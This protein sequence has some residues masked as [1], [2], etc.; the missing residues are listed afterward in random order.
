MRYAIYGVN[1][2]AKDFL[3]VFD[4][5]DVVCFFDESGGMEFMGRQV[6]SIKD[7]HERRTEWDKLILCDFDKEAKR[8]RLEQMGLRQGIEFIYEED[9]FYELDDL[10]LNPERKKIAV[11]GTGRRAEAFRIWNKRYTVEL[12]IDSYKKQ[13]AF[14]GIPIKEPS[15]IQDWKE[16]FIIIAAADDREIKNRLKAEGLE[17]YKD[18]C[19]SQEIMWI[20]SELLRETIFE[21]ERYDFQCDTMLNHAELG[22]EGAIHSCCTTFVDIAIG[23]IHK[24]G[25]N[26]IWQGAI[27]KILC[28]SLQNRTY[29][30]CKKDMCPLFIGRKPSENQEIDVRYSPMEKKP[31][32]VLLG[33]DETCNLKCVTCRHELRIAKGE[34]L[35]KVQ[36]YAKAA[37][38]ELLPDCE[39][40]ILAGNG[41]VFASQAYKQVYTNERMEHIKQL[42]LL[43]NGTLFTENNWNSIKRG[44]NMKVMLTVSIDAASKETYE[45]IRRGGSFEQLQKNMLFASQLRKKGDLSY[46]RMNFVVQKAN[47]REMTDFVKWGLELGADEV[48]FTKILNWGTYTEAEFREVSMMEEDGI[49]PKAELQEVLDKPIMNQPIVDM[50]TIR[51]SHRQVKDTDNVQNYYM[52]ELERKV[53]D[54]FDSSRGEE[55]QE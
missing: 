16:Q 22:N 30:F 32:T 5:L 27:H 12:Y 31:S 51:S 11:W 49:T 26:E 6:Y 42:R 33:Y 24:R 20:P 53:P 35:Q 28:L 25:F 7:F 41:E 37:V 55:R 48:F 9:M 19:N 54:L 44:E 38:D 46:F 43:T 34:A 17:E 39:F 45:K 23:N 29:S 14:Y 2:V 4:K 21:K 1:R 10:A 52:W 15:E 13:E 18:F 50:G 47:Y 36:G 3:Y 40:L 8:K